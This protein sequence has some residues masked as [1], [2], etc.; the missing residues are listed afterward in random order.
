MSSIS[1][2]G[3]VPSPMQTRIACETEAAR[4]RRSIATCA[5]RWWRAYCRWDDRLRQRRRLAALED[6]LLADIG[7]SYRQ[8]QREARR[9]FLA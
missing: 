7:V 9:W 5:A 4:P 1:I 2:T 3:E 6:H 8:A